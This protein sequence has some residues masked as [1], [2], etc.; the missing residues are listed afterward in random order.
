M[1]IYEIIRIVNLL[2]KVNCKPLALV[3]EVAREMGVKKTALMQ[4]IEDNP[5]LFRTE[6]MV[7]RSRRGTTTAGLAIRDTYPTAGDNPATDEWLELRRKEWE[8][9]LHVAAYD[10]YGHIEYHYF[11][12]DNPKDSLR[13]GLWRNTPEKFRELEEAGILKKQDIGSGG[14]GDYS[15]MERYVYNDATAEALATHGWT[16]DY[17]ENRR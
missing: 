2:Q 4:F 11:P 15:V 7:S 17:E 6:E 9:K 10:Y 12:E 1:N 8:K 13:T 5:K 14:F 16:T 3:S